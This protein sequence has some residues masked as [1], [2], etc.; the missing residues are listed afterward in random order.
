MS[1][2]GG[3]TILPG[4]NNHNHFENVTSANVLSEIQEPGA[5]DPW[6]QAHPVGFAEPFV[7]NTGESNRTIGSNRSS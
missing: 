5:Q 7:Y 2:G 1:G 3:Y 4:K 6:I